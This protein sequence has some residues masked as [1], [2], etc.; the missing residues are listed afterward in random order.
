MPNHPGQAFTVDILKMS[1]KMVTVAVD[2]FSGFVSTTFTQSEKH[3]DL[4]EGIITTVSQ[5]RV[6]QAPG[7]KALFKKNANLKDLGIE[8][9]L[10]ESKNK[11]KLALADKKMQEL[12]IEIKKA[13]PNPNVINVRILA[14]ATAVVNEKIR[15]QGLS[16]KEIMFSRDQLTQEN[17][18]ISDETLAEEKMEIRKKE[19]VYS[20]KSKASNKEQAWPA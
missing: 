13:A 9:E 20:A 3:E 1:K 18:K 2:N 17:L 16:A 19:N 8:I 11:N 5:I 14:R 15:H 4:L 10:G 12:E 7:F 6:D